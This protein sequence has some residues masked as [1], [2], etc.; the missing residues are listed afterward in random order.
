MIV[1]IVYHTRFGNNASIAQR[2]SDRLESL[3]HGVSLHPVSEA[4]TSEIPAADLYLT[5]SPTQI[6]TLPM[7]AGRFFRN[8]K[9]VDHSLF[10]TFATWAEPDSVTAEKMEEIMKDHGARQ[11]LPSLIFSVKDLRGPIEEG[12]ETKTDAWADQLSESAPSLLKKE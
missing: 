10:A 4:R 5:G 11:L 8:M 12:W 2:I 9:V 3:G 1:S 7:R 6:G